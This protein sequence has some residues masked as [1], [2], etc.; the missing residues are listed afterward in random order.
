MRVNPR[1]RV[2]ATFRAPVA[3]CESNLLLTGD[4]NGQPLG[5]MGTEYEDSF[6]VAGAAGSGDEGQATGEVAIESFTQKR[7][8]SGQVGEHLD[9]PCDHDVVG[10]EDRE[11]APAIGA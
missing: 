3:Q 11:C 8:G 4:K 1:I 7:E 5:A 6:D 10:R 2:K 9:F